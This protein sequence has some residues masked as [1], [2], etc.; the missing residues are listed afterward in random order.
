[1]LLQRL[2]LAPAL[3][4]R[5]LYIVRM[6]RAFACMANAP[7]LSWLTRGYDELG[8]PRYALAALCAA[9]QA[10][11]I[12]MTWPLW[13]VRDEPP[14]LPVFDIP[15]IPFGWVLQLSL[16]LV[17]LRPRLGL[18][19]HLLLLLGSFVFDQFRTQPQFIATAVLMLAVV[20]NRA[21]GLGRWFL[22]SIWLWS[23]LHKFLSPDWWG[24]SSW[25][26]VETLGLEPQHYF[27]AF[28]LAIALLETSQGLLAI[29]RPRYA[30]ISCIVL[31]AGIAIFL[32]PWMIDW[33]FSVIPWNLCTAVVGAWL[34]WNASPGVPR[35]RFE[36]VAAAILLGFPAGFYLGWV[37]HGIAGVLYSRNLPRG[38]I[39]A[40][41]GVAEIK[42]WGSLRVPFPNERRLLRLYFARSAAPG[43]KLH[44]S[45]PRPW[46]DD[47]YFLKPAVGSV[48]EISKSRFFRSS[49]AEV[50]GV[51]LDSSRDVFALSQAGVRMLKRT[52]DAMIY[53]VE[54]PPASYD[55]ELLVHLHGL[56]NLEQIQLAGCQV[57]DSE[58]GQ[59]SGLQNLRG[60]GLDDTPVTDVGLSSLTDL[61]QLAYI[62]HR[63]TKITSE[64]LRRLNVR[65]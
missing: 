4:Y 43:S 10:V 34:L 52:P 1:M 55:A 40:G 33:N 35:T 58:L 37:D 21:T 15:Q 53:A 42:G 13:Q 54:I 64:A 49:A 44:I 23:G 6:R 25:R 18:R 27:Q 41:E 30:A 63:N 51:A 7:R 39:S 28:A 29:V 32:S 59:L 20:E 16:L 17:L 5:S 65:D 2:H 24:P 47:Q 31:H 45:D 48:V 12:V 19:V 38:L 14:H 3:G 46:L 11:T 26:F 22:V 56:P 61:P 50:T 62:E 36:A 8:P 60:I 9:C 57:N